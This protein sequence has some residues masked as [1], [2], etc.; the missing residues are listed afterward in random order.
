MNITLSFRTV[1]A[2]SILLYLQSFSYIDFLALEMIEGSLV[3]SYNLGGGTNPINS[4]TD[5]RYDD[6]VLHTVSSHFNH[7]SAE[8][9][10][11]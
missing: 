6:G 3:Y 2:S 5:V 4:S 10:L 8:E 11:F 9:L 1:S 7:L